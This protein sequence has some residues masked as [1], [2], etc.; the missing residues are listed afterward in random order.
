MTLVRLV[1]AV[2]NALP[3]QGGQ[4]EQRALEQGERGLGQ[5]RPSRRSIF[6]SD[7]PPSKS[8]TISAPDVLSTYPYSV[9]R[10]GSTNRPSPR[11]PR[12]SQRAARRRRTASRRGT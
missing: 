4:T 8:M 7:A 9:T 10:Y 1:V 6:R 12:G 11:P 2:R 5:S 3:V